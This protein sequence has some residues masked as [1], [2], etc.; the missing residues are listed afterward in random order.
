MSAALDAWEGAGQPLL[1]SVAAAPCVVWDQPTQ[2]GVLG[3]ASA[4]PGTAP[5]V[6][7][8]HSIPGEPWLHLESL[9]CWDGSCCT[10]GFKCVLPSQDL[11]KILWAS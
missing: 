5:G 7:N 6:R 1:Q 9:L 11:P 2:A 4:L 3:L 8:Y 10:Q